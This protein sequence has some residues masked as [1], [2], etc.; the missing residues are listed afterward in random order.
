V[1]VEA[2]GEANQ[3]L[4]VVVVEGEVAVVI[5]DGTETSTSMNHASLHQEDTTCL[6]LHEVIGEVVSGRDLEPGLAVLPGEGDTIN[7][8][9]LCVVCFSCLKKIHSFYGI[10]LARFSRSP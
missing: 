2:T 8:F 4:L 6:R 10:Y 3:P 7:C 5:S 1:G 9:L